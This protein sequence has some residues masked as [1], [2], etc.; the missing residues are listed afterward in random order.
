MASRPRWQISWVSTEAVSVGEQSL[1][2]N[3]RELRWIFFENAANA[4]TWSPRKALPFL[5]AS[6]GAVDRRDAIPSWVWDSGV[7]KMAVPMPTAHIY[8]G[9]HPLRVSST[10]YSHKVTSVPQEYSWTIL[11]SLWDPRPCPA[12][13]HKTEDWLMEGHLAISR[14]SSKNDHQQLYSALPHFPL[15][16]LLRTM[17]HRL[18]REIPSGFSCN[19]SSWWTGVR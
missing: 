17:C 15:I 5:W 10:P 1:A 14:T 4:P 6:W 11:S 9:L 19:S 8:S 16:S 13:Q 2:G 12:Q 3:T 7:P 18:G